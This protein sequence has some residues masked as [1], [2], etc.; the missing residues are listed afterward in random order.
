[1]NLCI[2]EGRMTRDAETRHTPNGQSVTNFS[3]A[4][5]EKWKDKN[6]D[7]KETVVF[8]EFEMWG[9]K[10]KLFATI[11]KGSRI[12]VQCEYV[13]QDWTDKKSNEKR[14]SH[15]FRVGKIQVIEYMNT[16]PA[17]NT[18]NTSTT[19]DDQEEDDIPF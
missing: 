2:F 14:K 16:T 13:Q 5:N 6:G 15:K 8:P 4:I 11:G 10:S 3:L 17:A 1:M 19:E 7:T 9:D 18:E 12:I